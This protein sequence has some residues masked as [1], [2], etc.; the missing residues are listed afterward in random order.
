MARVDHHTLQRRARLAEVLLAVI[1]VAGAALVGRLIVA[2]PLFSNPLTVSVDLPGAAG[3]HPHSDVSYRGQHIGSVTAVDLT[4]TGVRATLHLESDISIP[5]DSDVVVANLSAVGEQY[6]DIRPRTADGPFLADGDVIRLDASALPVPTWQVL[7]HAQH[8]LR[9][10][11]TADLHTIAREITALFGRGDADLGSLLTELENTIDMLERLT[12]TALALVRHGERPL[13]TMDDLS[14][15]FRSLVSNAQK[16]MRRLGSSNDTIAKL[17]DD[18]ATLVPVV[19]KDFDAVS[20]VLVRLLDDGTP[21]AT[22]ARKH[23]PGLLHW[24]RWAPDQ[25]V[26]MAESTRDQ[27]GHV[28]LVITP[29]DN[30]RY[31]KEFSPYQE[32][33]PLLVNARCTTVD[34]HIQQRGSQ[35]VPRP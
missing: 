10:V 20:P 35:Y 9:R 2:G 7:G 29:A 14:P 1:L 34:P 30:C 4:D 23:L 27:S 3:L 24:Y 18:G 16:V 31:G 19:V 6:V 8:L 26:A 28:I 21:V 5:R 22:M 13:R 11:D 33:V 17:I 15:E 12:P 25:L 32:D